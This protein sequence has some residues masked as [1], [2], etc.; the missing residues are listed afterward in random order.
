MIN[1]LAIVSLIF[2]SPNFVEAGMKVINLRFGVNASD[3]Y[4]SMFLKMRPITRVLEKELSKEL[5]KKVSISFRVI[6]G[7]KK[8]IDTFVKGEIDFGR[9]GPASYVLAKQKNPNLRLLAMENKKGKRRFN[10]LIIVRA[11]SHYKALSDL[12]RV[13]FAFG[14]EISTIG[15]Y[16]SQVELMNAGI[17]ARSLRAFSYLGRHGNVFRAVERGMYDAGA[18]KESAF[19]KNNKKGL[20]RILHSFDNVTKPW[21]VRAGLQSEIFNALRRIMLDLKDS[22][23]FKNLGIKGFFS[24][25]H[26]EYEY[27][28]RAMQQVSL[29]E[30]CI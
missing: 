24:A 4:D 28:E 2:V 13:K 5:G 14:S 15:R 1:V 19:R 10:G 6:H 23:A 20:V 3:N 16:L 29:F 22:K 11:N 12:H 17:C 9:L 25:S 27:V 26:K 30:S 21:L 18:L 7:Y 8:T